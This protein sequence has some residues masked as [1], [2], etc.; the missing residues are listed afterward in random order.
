MYCLFLKI[1][2]DVIILALKKN[3]MKKNALQNSDQSC[4]DEVITDT[5]SPYEKGVLNIVLKRIQRRVVRIFSHIVPSH[6]L[7]MSPQTEPI[8]I[9]I[10]RKRSVF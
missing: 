4:I 6:N 2:A 10:R 3:T 7:Q 1:V 8:N 5:F 9:L